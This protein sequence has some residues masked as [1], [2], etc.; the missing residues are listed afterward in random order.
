MP[1]SIGLADALL[2]HR[3]PARA[4]RVLVQ[5]QGLVGVGLADDDGRAV[6]RPLVLAGADELVACGGLVPAAGLVALDDTR[7][8]CRRPPPGHRRLEAATT[9]CRLTFSRLAWRSRSARRR[10]RAAVFAAW[11]FRLLMMMFSPGGRAHGRVRQDTCGGLRVLRGA[12]GDPG[13]AGISLNERRR[14]TAATPSPGSARGSGSRAHGGLPRSRGRRAGGP[15]GPR[16]HAHRRDREQ[17]RPERRRAAAAPSS[18]ASA[19]SPRRSQAAPHRADA[20]VR[21]AAARRCPGRRGP[22]G[23][24]AGRR[25]R[26][27]GHAGERGAH[28]GAVAAPSTIAKPNCASLSALA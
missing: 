8:R 2:E 12:P 24:P 19:R 1:S 3:P 10:S 16:G 9:T 11:L 26:R 28:A 23:P 6:L 5:V 21:A 17:Q 27:R 15:P 13:C 25:P 4:A 22:A 14:S 7:S 18:W 20:D